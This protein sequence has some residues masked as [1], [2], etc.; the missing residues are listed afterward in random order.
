M[1][2]QVNK[3]QV[4]AGNAR[5]YWRHVIETNS[6]KLELE[7]EIPNVL[8]R[9]IFDTQIQMSV[10]G[11]ISVLLARKSIFVFFYLYREFID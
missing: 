6:Q 5:T 4:G 1:N 9:L 10:D 11:T 3:R 8:V 7:L 2:K